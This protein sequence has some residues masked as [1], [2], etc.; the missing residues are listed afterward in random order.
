MIEVLAGTAWTESELLGL[1]RSLAARAARAGE[2]PDGPRQEELMC[3]EH[4]SVWLVRWDQDHDT[5]FHDHDLSAGAVAVVEGQVLEER[6]TLGG[7]T[8]SRIA[9]P[10]DCFTVSTADIHRISHVS[11]APAVTIHAYSPPLRRMG[12]YEIEPEPDRVGGA[13]RRAAIRS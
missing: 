11:G 8:R 4:V 1:V 9:S 13:E 2:A 6:L 12:R 7:P 5:G 3:T 10:G